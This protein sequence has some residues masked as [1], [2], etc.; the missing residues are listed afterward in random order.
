MVRSLPKMQ[1]TTACMTDKGRDQHVS[2]PPVWSRA[3]A[4][5]LAV[6]V[7]SQLSERCFRVV[8]SLYRIVHA[9]GNTLPY[10][11]LKDK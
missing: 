8:K 10:L 7:H 6:V 9:L 1:K 5:V 3:P 2:L 4:H 11:N